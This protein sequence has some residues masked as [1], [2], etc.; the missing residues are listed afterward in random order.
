MRTAWRRLVSESA[1][2][3]ALIAAA[4]CWTGVVAAA[5]RPA[6]QALPDE[7][8]GVVRLPDLKEAL[9]A[10][11]TRTK[12]GALAFEAK[13]VDAIKALI[14]QEAK[15]DVDELTAEL[16]K[17][18]LTFDD[19]LE[20]LQGE[21]GYAAT[22]AKLD[23]KPAYVGLLWIE[24]GEAPAEK[25]LTALD[26]IL[27][28][29]KDEIG[30]AERDDLELAGVKVRRLRIPMVEVDV[31]LEKEGNESKKEEKISDYVHA[32]VGRHEGKLL[33]AHTLESKRG[34]DAEDTDDDAEV[35][36]RETALREHAT[37]VFARFSEAQ[38]G[39][40]EGYVQRKMQTPGLAEAL[41]EGV[42]IVDALLDIPALLQLVDG[43][44][45]DELLKM[46]RAFGFA[47][48]G[49]LAYR[50]TLDG[51]VLR[52][53]LFLA[54]PNPRKG[55]LK[56]LDQAPI[57]PK[58]ADWVAADVTGY[59]H[60]SIDFGGVY[61]LVSDI[62]RNE[63]PKGGESI[64]W[65]E[66]Q[67]KQFVQTDVATFLS[68]LGTKH[69]VLQFVP[70]KAEAGK[71]VD[72]TSQNSMALVWRPTDVALWK[73]LMQT[74]ALVAA[75]EAV[76]ERGFTGLRHDQDAFHGGWFI[77][78]GVMM[79]A[80]GKG[81]TERTLSMLRTPPQAD[82]SLAGS[83]IA[84]RAAELLPPQDAIMYDLTNGPT[85]LKL[86]NEAISS[87]MNDPNDPASKKLKPIWPEEKELEGSIGVSVS[88]AT[89]N[90]A[91]FTYRGASD[92]PPP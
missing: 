88:A 21:V 71:G 24:C 40:G 59:Q 9:E 12:L 89:I 92:L 68:S 49:P 81:V 74:V 79:V 58:P 44:Q 52:S 30:K 57:A 72:E 77:G 85:L 50:M 3:G 42:Q 39:D 56:L 48:L 26:K 18:G 67:A 41:P 66:E 82:A 47:D 80:I 84:A 19:L 15:A 8:I 31:K 28:A 13:R 61:K 64:A 86:I 91:G 76:E 73:R 69:T 36:Q 54:A 83:P 51:H 27:E 46:L 38:A 16:L 37:A 34:L 53:G 6:W 29:Q 7:T 55:V 2:L 14:L 78:D 17:V 35:K 60:W 1:W 20:S 90:D 43:P 23:D 62:M 33:L 87:A 65:L 25:L 70:E 5:E 11:K 63:S 22:V 45:N 75:K 32:L 4:I 10:F